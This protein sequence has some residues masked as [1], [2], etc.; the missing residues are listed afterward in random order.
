MNLEDIILALVL[1]VAAS[2]IV[3][4][5]LGLFY[6][7][8]KFN[9]DEDISPY[10]SPLESINDAKNALFSSSILDQQGLVKSEPIIN[11]LIPEVET[12]KVEANTNDHLEKS[13]SNNS[14]NV[15]CASE[16]SIAKPFN[17]TPWESR[18]IL[19][20]DGTD[21]H[22]NGTRDRGKIPF[23]KKSTIKVRYKFPK[24]QVKISYL[25]PR[26]FRDGGL[27]WMKMEIH[28]KRF[29]FTSGHRTRLAVGNTKVT[30]QDIYEI[31][32]EI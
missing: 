29:Y 28:N 25:P 18:G 6:T 14:F 24:N 17:F 7:S 22:F 23:L 21:I 9:R 19:V 13:N 3:Y 16:R 31:I 15:F 20:F 2:I 27:S 1:S 5:L 26:V 30:T 32:S 4:R 10:P 8:W 12:S 11:S